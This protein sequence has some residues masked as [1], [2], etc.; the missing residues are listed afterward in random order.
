MNYK[1]P[2]L[3]RKPNLP[4]IAQAAYKE[5]HAFLEAVTQRRMQHAMEFGRKYGTASP[6]KI[7]K[8]LAA[9]PQPTGYEAWDKAVAEPDR[10]EQAK[11]GGIQEHSVGGLLPFILVGIENPRY[12]IHASEA[13]CASDRFTLGH[14]EGTY[15]YVQNPDGSIGSRLFATYDAAAHYAEHY[16]LP[17]YKAGLPPDRYTRADWSWIQS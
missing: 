7:A 1:V 17:R 13:F 5:A 2:S 11:R 12:D 15:W 8:A 3:L 6:A 9:R 16:Q 14:H 10:V 4:G